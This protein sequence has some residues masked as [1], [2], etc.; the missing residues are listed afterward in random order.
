MP[1]RLA[2]VSGTVAGRVFEFHDQVVSLGRAAGNT[3]ELN[4]EQ[5]VSG[6]HC[7]IHL[8]DGDW[9]VTDLGSTNGTFLNGEQVEKPM[10][11]RDKAHLRLGRKG[12]EFMVHLEYA[13]P[14]GRRPARQ[15]PQRTIPAAEMMAMRELAVQPIGI[16]PPSG[17]IANAPEYPDMAKA[18]APVA[19]DPALRPT[20]ILGDL[21]RDA[22]AQIA[23]AFPP[24][25]TTK[26]LRLIKQ[27]PPPPPLPPMPPPP[28]PPPEA[29][30]PAPPR[31]PPPAQ[32]R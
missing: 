7:Q 22:P 10:L 5:R 13:F 29:E 19:D 20:K 2:C 9:F 12:P 27:P 25:S 23:G 3:L 31:P 17:A 30:P 32:N 15:D 16:P 24:R 14:E 1:I 18:A 11:L 26:M 21:R 4:Q 8:E 6:R 28:P